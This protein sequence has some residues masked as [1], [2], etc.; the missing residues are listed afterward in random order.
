MI[1]HS[2]IDPDEVAFYERLA[3]HWWDENGPF[4]PLHRMNAGRVGYI[5][6]ILSAEFGR[7]AIAPQPLQGL[8]V[9]DIGCGGGI[10]SE[11]VARLGAKVHGVDVVARNIHI[12]RLHAERTG[13]AVDY[14][15][16]SAEILAGRGESYDAVLNMEVVE[17][18]AELDCFV[19]ACMRLIRP[20]GVM[21][22]ATINR[23]LAS[24]LGA[25]VMAEYVLRWLP[26]GTHRWRRFPQ[27]LEL[28]NLLESGGMKV[29]DRTGVAVN[30]FG[31]GFSLTSYMGINYMLAAR[32]PTN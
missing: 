11:A 13:L 16:A 31:W 20:G 29:F 24:W 3:E 9:L 1:R 18:V 23:T 12:A 26:I 8:R 25:I 17:H 27:P 22:V 10:L 7:D 14:E 21:I 28:E 2:S 6:D 32:K 30:P 5:R 4:W 19:N 15:V